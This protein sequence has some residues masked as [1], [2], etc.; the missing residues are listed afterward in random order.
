MKKIMK[1]NFF[2]GFLLLGLSVLVL[3]FGLSSLSLDINSS[4]IN[5]WEICQPSNF[6]PNAFNIFVLS[7]TIALLV[8]LVPIVLTLLSIF[9]K[10]N[11]FFFIVLF[12]QLA[13]QITF[14][15]MQGVTLELSAGAMT[16]AIINTFLLII[17]FGLLFLRRAFNKKP[18]DEVV[19]EVK[20]IAPT[21]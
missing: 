5:L 3:I 17:A 19:A 16:F 2:T 6:T 20:N 4:P 21:F 15:I 7:F 12:Y 14:F 1:N 18:T 9:R 11:I 10:N 13:I 8:S